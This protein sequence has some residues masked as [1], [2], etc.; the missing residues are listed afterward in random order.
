M[1]LC[2]CSHWRISARRRLFHTCRVSLTICVCAAPYLTA[3]YTN[4]AVVLCPYDADPLLR[5]LARQRFSLHVALSLADRCS[6]WSVCRLGLSVFSLAGCWS[7]LVFVLVWLLAAWLVGWGLGLVVAVAAGVWWV[8]WLGCLVAGRPGRWLVGLL[9]GVSGWACSCWPRSVGNYYATANLVLHLSFPFFV[10]EVL[11]STNLE[12][13][14]T[15]LRM[16][17]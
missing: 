17:P 13:S 2:I 14:S 16:R 8:G 4:H 12:S 15:L 5:R 3:D 10:C 11:D 1:S 6:S 7:L 9:S